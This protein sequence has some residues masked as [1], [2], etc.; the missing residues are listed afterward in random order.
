MYNV[1]ILQ[2]IIAMDTMHAKVN[3]IHGEYYCQL[4]GNKEF[5]VEAYPM[6]NKSDCHEA[7]DNFVKYYGAPDSM[8][9]NGAQ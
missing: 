9:Y 5:F 6:E 3:S 7:L 2:C 1:K 4:S 8:I